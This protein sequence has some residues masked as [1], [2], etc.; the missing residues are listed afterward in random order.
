MS[1]REVGVHDVRDID[2]LYTKCK[3]KCYL[4]LFYSQN[5]QKVLGFGLSRGAS[6]VGGGF[7]SQ[8]NSK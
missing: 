5:V 3:I 6:K 2:W 1:I 8:P 4:T 7:F